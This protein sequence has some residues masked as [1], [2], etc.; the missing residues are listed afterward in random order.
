VTY[1]CVPTAPLSLKNAGALKSWG[2]KHARWIHARVNSIN[3]SMHVTLEG[4]SPR[5]VVEPP[6]TIDEINN[7]LIIGHY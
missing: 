3:L 1:C 7:W 2:T 4:V 5:R 6:L